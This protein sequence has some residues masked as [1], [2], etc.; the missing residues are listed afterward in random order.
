[1]AQNP[2]DAAKAVLKGKFSAIKSYLKKQEK[3][4]INSLTLHLQQS[5]EE[6]QK[7]PQS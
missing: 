5:E 1:M 4:Q 3:P 7:N 6:E 2:W